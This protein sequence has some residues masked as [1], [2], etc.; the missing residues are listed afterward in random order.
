MTDGS[1]QEPMKDE[2]T[3]HLSSISPFARDL[4]HQRGIAAECR[5]AAHAARQ[6]DG[7][8]FPELTQLRLS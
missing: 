4:I 1:T 5:E 6:I 8:N 7:A 3:I 2:L